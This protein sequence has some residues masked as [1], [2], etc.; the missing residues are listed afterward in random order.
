MKRIISFITFITFMLC[1]LLSTLPALAETPEGTAISTSSEFAEMSASGKYYL[2]EDITVSNYYANVFSGTLD[3]NGY[4]III[5]DGVNVSPF[6]SI[7]GATFKNLT[8]EGNIVITSKRTYG[9]IAAEGYGSFENVTAHVGISA[10]IEDSFTGVGASQGGFIGVATGE[11]SFVNCKNEASITVITET[12]TVTSNNAAGF[13]GFIGSAS[14]SGARISFVGCK[15]NAAIVSL[16]PGINVGGFIGVSNNSNLSFESCQNNAFVT[17]VAQADAHNGSGGFVGVIFS[18]VLSVKNCQNNCDVINEGG[19]GH[20]GG[21]VGRM[22]AVRNV[23]FD[24]F[25]NT[26]AVYNLSSYWEGVGGVVGI[27]GDLNDG[28]GIYLFRDC[29]NNGWVQGSMAGGIIGIDNGVDGVDMRFERCVNTAWVKTLGIAYSAGILGRT[30]GEL[31]SL[32]FTQCVNTGDITTSDGA[33]GVAGICG[34]IGVDGCT[35]SYTP[36]FDG[37]V[38]AGNLDCHSNLSVVYAAGILSRN[39]YMKTVIKNCV[40]IGTLSNSYYSS[41]TAA[42]T[43][44]YDSVTYSV[45]GCSYL[46]GTCSAS[47][48]ES[49]KSIDNIK[50]DVISSLTSGLSAESEYYNYR[51]SDSEINSVG[52]GVDKVLAAS[53]VAEISAGAKQITINRSSLV[54]MSDKRAELIAEVGAPIDNADNKYTASSYEAYLTA[55]EQI[56]TDINEA[57]DATAI[58]SISVSA[59]KSE[60]EAMLELYFEAPENDIITPSNDSASKEFTVTYDKAS[61]SIDAVYSVDVVWTD[62]SFTYSEGTTRWDPEKH[63]FSSN[64]DDA[65][66]VDGTGEITVTNHSN[67][68]VDVKLTFDTSNHL[69]G[70]ANIIIDNSSFVLDSAVGTTFDKA[71]SQTSSVTAVGVPTQSGAFGVLTVELSKSN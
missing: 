69:N 11:T 10:M 48:G 41:N 64:A 21:F 57:V 6:I 61:S 1:T 17:G 31:L 62:I 12:K 44:K 13:G 71:P 39:I 58:D 63:D 3:G 20:T 22:S 35:Y 23:I 4:K 5:A 25:K 55:F 28:N 38:N 32:T 59:L 52:E 40:N 54:L 47:F 51:N 56:K 53:S 8:V 50:A 9:G 43:P 49:A 24:S 26:R 16:E 68:P 19:T 42:T 60:A 15:N 70:T 2:T 37:C 27:M 34:N 29:V 7:A 30:N 36:T 66:W 65:G 14:P 18:N 33:Y 67:A 46:S 45:S